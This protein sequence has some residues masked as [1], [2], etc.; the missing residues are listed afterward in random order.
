MIVCML[1]LVT[2]AVAAMTAEDAEEILLLDAT[3]GE[4]GIV[5]VL[6]TAHHRLLLLEDRVIGIEHRAVES[7]HEAAFAGMV[8]PRTLELERG[9]NPNAIGLTPIGIVGTYG[10]CRFLASSTRSC[11]GPRTGCWHSPLVST[12]YQHLDGRC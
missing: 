7:R 6:K 5:S 12:S 10:D 11:L 9:D 4:Y 1:L 3:L 8:T 2:P